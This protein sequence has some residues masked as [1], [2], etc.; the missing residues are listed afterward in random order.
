[1]LTTNNTGNFSSADFALIVASLWQQSP[2]L[3]T[4]LS[5]LELSWK[6]PAEFLQALHA[7]HALRHQCLSKNSL[8]LHYD[9]YHDLVVRH[10]QVK[11]PA[12]VWFENGK[13]QELSYTELEQTV[14]ALSASWEVAGV[15]AKE[16]L[17]ILHN[18][19]VQMLTAILAGLRLGLVVSLLP[20]QGSEFVSLRLE[21]L[22]PD[23]LAI[24]QLYRHQLTTDW[25]EKLLPNTLSSKPPTRLSYE[26]SST[27]VVLKCFDPT[28]STPEVATSVNATRLY[29]GALRD[30]VLA[31]SI[32][33]GH[34]CT[35]PGWHFLESQPALIFAVLISGATWVEMALSELKNNPSLLVE[36]PVDILGVSGDLRDQLLKTPPEGEMHWKFWFRHPSE[37]TDLTVWQEFI[38]TLQLQQSFSGNLICNSAR[39]GGLIFSTKCQ[40]VVNHSVLPAAA[41]PWQL[42][43][44]S[45]PEL[46]AHGHTGQLA[47]AEKQN[48]ETKWTAT[49][50][51]LMFS[52]KARTYLGHYPKGRAGRTYPV[53]EV[54][55]VVAKMVKYFTIVETGT[56]DVDDQDILILLLFGKNIDTAALQT[57]IEQSLG[58]EFLPDRIECL[59]LLPKLNADQQVDKAWSQF[60]FETG[61][62]YLRER[63]AIYQCLYTLK[64]KILM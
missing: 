21:N 61:E 56:G 45:F 29:W 37:S 39:G 31:L 58:S 27:D 32:E 64:N 35:A 14:N 11:T 9:F 62:L 18:P 47:L 48:N 15:K 28:S 13:K 33:S 7:Y 16:T 54:A 36:Q 46:P 12:F 63:S 52:D 24:E 4:D 60:H 3:S 8:F 2:R 44:L 41:M 59:N 10:K 57:C 55:A 26:Y 49:P 5:W 1:M 34:R 30:S 23:W 22:A 43:I 42:S 6:Q 51:L 25:Q 53:R 20:P 38:T 50:Y 19:G 40:G 17:A